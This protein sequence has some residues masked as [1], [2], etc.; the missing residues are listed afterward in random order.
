VILDT[1]RLQA[2]PAYGE[3]LRQRFWRDGLFATQ[4][5]GWKG[6]TERAHRPVFNLYPPINPDAP[7]SD[8]SEVRFFLHMDPRK[9]YKTTFNR[10]NSV[11]WLTAFPEEITIL[12]QSSTQ[13]LAAEIGETV[14]GVFYQ[15][16][17]AGSNAVHL[18]W[19]SLV[20]TKEP[21][22]KW[23]F[24]GKGCHDSMRDLDS[25]MDFTS[26]K[27]SQS[28]WH[29]YIIKSDDV[30]DPDN[31][32]ITAGSEV[33]RNVIDKCDQN[34]N[35]LREGGY[36]FI[37]GTRYHPFDWYGNCIER[38]Q[39]NPEMWKVL[40]RCSIVRKDGGR[41]LPDQFPRENECELQFPE[42]LSL[43]YKALKDI[44]ETNYESFMC[45]QQN[46]PQGGAIARFD[47]KIFQSCVIPGERV[48]RGGETFLCWRPR[49]T[50][51]KAM[52]K[53]AEG[54]CGRFIADG[55]IIIV[56]A[57]Q[58]QYTASGE[59]EKLVRECRE[60]EVDQLLLIEVPGAE[61]I[62]AN[63]RNE[64]LRRNRS[65]RM[66][67]IWWEEN[68]ARRVAEIESLDPMMKVGRLLFSSAMG[69]FHECRNQFVYFGL[70]E[71]NGI[72]DCIAQ[73]AG[74]IP[75]S[76]WRANMEDEEI[77]AQRRR[78]NDLQLSHVLSIQGQ[79]MLDEEARQKEA[80]HAAAMSQ[81]VNQWYPPLPGGLDG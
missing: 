6:F 70:V 48:P 42:F 49:Y 24:P 46:D 36:H 79:N 47:A 13:P 23:D 78:A 12:N 44:Y 17:N 81:V 45:Q 18:L 77:E 43:S 58:G 26:P 63:V 75:E 41:L 31:S 22:G 74:R 50:G 4:L 52:S 73:L 71:Q 3:D 14:G 80:A 60:H 9:T 11:Q 29:P 62:M 67:W 35:L 27:S 40:I 55:K 59:A 76:V 64:A 28:G 51:N 38:A 19:P 20:L 32:G 53:Y 1:A 54:A 16:K 21:G 56:D 30:E 57:W 61:H 25:T 5:L 66:N 34:E 39:R 33:R 10:V 72:A 8:Q 68:D 2:D 69:K 65:I 15:R 37:V 7:I